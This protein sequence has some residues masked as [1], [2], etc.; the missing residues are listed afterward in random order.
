MATVAARAFRA[1]GRARQSEEAFLKAFALDRSNQE[2]AEG[3]ADAVASAHRRCDELDQKGQAS[4]EGR[5]ALEGK[6]ESLERRCESLERQQN[7]PQ[8]QVLQL[9]SSMVWDLSSY[10]FAD[11]RKGQSQ[12]SD[13]FQLLSSGVIARLGLYPKG[14][15]NSSEGMAGLFLWVDKPCKVKW[16]CQPGSREVKTEERD[17]S[18]ASLNPNGTP[19]GWG[20]RNFMRI[21]ETN[22]TVTLRI[23]S[24]QAPGSTMRFS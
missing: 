3:L 15:A 22:G 10:D 21:S 23:L 5:K 14:H 19:Q 11:F 16:T 17:F 24:V 18:Q 2:A 9:H 20:N 13:K 4:E 7:A 8:S 1:K 12:E 6:C